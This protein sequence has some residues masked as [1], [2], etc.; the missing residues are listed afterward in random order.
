MAA[1]I[2]IRRGGGCKEEEEDVGS[3]VAERSED[4][5]DEQGSQHTS[6]AAL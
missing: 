1:T 3:T 5:C 2:V 6:T 4:G